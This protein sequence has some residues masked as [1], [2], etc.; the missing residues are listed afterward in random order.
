MDLIHTHKR[1]HS[2][3]LL[4]DIRA[5]IFS[6]HRPM[7]TINFERC[8]INVMHLKDMITACSDLLFIMG[9]QEGRISHV[10]V[11]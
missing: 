2:F 4:V 1:I 5:G 3:L 9:I 7:I 11:W 10:Q 6:D 8:I